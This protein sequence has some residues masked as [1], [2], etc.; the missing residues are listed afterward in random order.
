[1]RWGR[2]SKKRDCGTTGSSTVV[3]GGRVIEGEHDT[4]TTKTRKIVI[5]N[6]K[7]KGRDCSTSYTKSENWSG[8]GKGSH[9][10]T[11]SALVRITQ[12]RRKTA[13]GDA[14]SYASNRAVG[15]Q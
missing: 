3:N 15:R 10:Y 2:K 13:Q 9:S 12:L 4:E 11:G 5:A 6:D 8:K 1:M 14:T 7:N